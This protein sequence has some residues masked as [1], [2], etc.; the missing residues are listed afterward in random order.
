MAHGYAG[1]EVGRGSVLSPATVAVGASAEVFS[2]TS[3]QWEHCKVVRVEDNIA[4]VA[5]Q[6]GGDHVQKADLEF[7][8]SPWAIRS[9]GSG[10][11]CLPPRDFDPC[12]ARASSAGPDKM[13]GTLKL[14]AILST[15]T[16]DAAA[17]KKDCSPPR[18]RYIFFLDGWMLMTPERF[19]GP[20]W[21]A[22]CRFWSASKERG[23]RS[24]K[25]P[26]SGWTRTETAL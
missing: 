2:S 3:G 20:S 21:K 4:T 13:R 23:W 14:G 22:P 10:A 18:Q 12:A 26:G 8:P 1:P 24:R 9:S 6:R 7:R 16:S 25:S 11:Q 15:W 17:K 19:P 5:Y